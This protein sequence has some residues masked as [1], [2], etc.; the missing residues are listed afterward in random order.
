VNARD[1]ALWLRVQ[2]RVGT[3]APPVR[4]RLLDAYRVLRESVSDAELT[5]LIASGQWEKILDDLLLKRALAPVREELVKVVEKG[6]KSAVPTLP[7]AG[8]VDGAVGVAFD[9]LN[10]RVIAAVR[11]LD[12]RAINTLDADIREGVRAVVRK[13]LRD[14]VSAR[15]I[16]RDL[17]GMIGLAPN[18]VEYVQNYRAE[19]EEGS[20]AALDRRLRNRRYDTA[21]ARGSM[22]PGQIDR[23]VAAYEK[24]LLDF[25]A[26]TNARTMAGDSLKLG[27]HLSWQDA[28][29]NGM[30][31]KEQVWK[32]WVGVMDDRERPEHVDME[33]ETVRYDSAFSN[34]QQIPGETD[35][36]CR[37]ILR[38]IVQPI[39]AGP[40]AGAL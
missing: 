34:G 35:F 2:R 33:G 4:A 14:G 18:Q 37:C 1:R 22:T 19:L 26:T 25:N 7:K 12:D 28:I 13:G 9:V 6:L 21:V 5:R 31:N 17:R 40:P 10:P 15:T 38:Y 3:L 32:R 16:G 23:A 29:D 27:Q 8:L 39:G 20:A 36:N 24:R 30:V 11:Q